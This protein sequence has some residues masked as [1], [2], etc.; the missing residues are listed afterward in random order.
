MPR[1]KNSVR[2]VG[3]KGR[4]R[5]IG[6][7]RGGKPPAELNDLSPEEQAVTALL[8]PPVPNPLAELGR[9]ISEEVG[10]ELFH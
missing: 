1:I 10:G 4:P 6:I 3:V 2:E 9:L 8:A 5:K 7:P